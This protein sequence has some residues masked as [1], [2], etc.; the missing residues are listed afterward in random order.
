M[1]STD[2]RHRLESQ[3]AHFSFSKSQELKPVLQVANDL[4]NSV[5]KVMLGILRS[6]FLGY[7]GA[8]L[9]LLMSGS[10]LDIQ[11]QGSLGP[12]R[13]A[14]NT[15]LSDFDSVGSSEDLKK[16]G[17]KIHPQ[18]FLQQSLCPRGLD[19]SSWL[20]NKSHLKLAE[21]PLGAQC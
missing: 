9:L 21:A 10:Q 11:I 5:F 15:S 17:K 19:K 2:P 20:H 8:S 12:P 3:F 14:K 4:E 18:P 16:R 6:I 13:T 7:E 1:M